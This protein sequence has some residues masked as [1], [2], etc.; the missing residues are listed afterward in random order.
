MLA[1]RMILPASVPARAWPPGE[2]TQISSIWPLVLSASCSRLG[3]SSSIIPSALSTR[4]PVEVSS[5]KRICRYVDQLR[6]LGQLGFTGSRPGWADAT[7]PS[8]M[9]A[10]VANW[11]NRRRTSDPG[12]AAR[13]LGAAHL[14]GDGRFL[15]IDDHD[16]S[17]GHAGAAVGK[18]LLSGDFRRPGHVRPR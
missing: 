12:V 8:S 2:R 7:L 11:T 5:V 4:T 15:A 18:L 10:A 16:V 3:T 14:L 9:D 1:L 17:D 6:S 13:A